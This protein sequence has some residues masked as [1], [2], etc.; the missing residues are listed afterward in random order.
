[1]IPESL[2]TGN[3]EIKF[4]LHEERTGQALTGT[5]TSL[6]DGQTARILI[7]EK[8]VV[9][10]RFDASKDAFVDGCCSRS[11]F[12]VENVENGINVKLFTGNEIKVQFKP[13]KIDLFSNGFHVISLNQK[14]L[15]KFELY[16]PKGWLLLNIFSILI[17]ITYLEENECTEEGCWDETFK[18]STDSKP[19]GN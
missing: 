15:F 11:N 9:R 10:Q 7:N 17:K 12:T 2:T 19:F 14:E 6:V 1:M 16:K 8:H 13:F 5:I 18:S 4:D 3:D